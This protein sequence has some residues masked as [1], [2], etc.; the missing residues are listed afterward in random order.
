MQK[1]GVNIGI[2]DK[3]GNDIFV[4]SVISHNN[5][6]YLIKW[7]DSQKQFVA[8][9]EPLK[10]K[11]KSWR[12]TEWIERLSYKYIEIVGTVLFDENMKKRFYGVAKGL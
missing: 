7:S 11:K 5:N 12:D 2:K 10:G 3:N 4:G 1:S 9:A 6:L 8:R